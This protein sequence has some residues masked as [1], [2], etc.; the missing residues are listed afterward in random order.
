MR[1]AKRVRAIGKVSDANFAIVGQQQA[2]DVGAARTV[3]ARVSVRDRAVCRARVCDGRNRAHVVVAVIV[4]VVI[5]AVGVVAVVVECN[6]R[7]VGVRQL[8][9]TLL[10]A[11]A[12]AMRK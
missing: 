5:V 8:R 11:H 12:S 7:G 1:L 2:D 9:A 3:I 10:L 6:R 4:G